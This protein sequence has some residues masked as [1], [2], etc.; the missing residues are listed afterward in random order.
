MKAH[1]VRPVAVFHE[2]IDVLR[3]GGAVLDV[4]RVLVHVERQDG[5]RSGHAVRMIG[6]PLIHE[7]AIAVRMR[8]QHP[9]G[10]P[11]VGIMCPCCWWCLRNVLSSA[12]TFM[13]TPRLL[14]RC[15]LQ[16]RHT[17]GVAARLLTSRLSFENYC[18]ITTDTP[19]GSAGNRRDTRTPVWALARSRTSA[20]EPGHKSPQAART[21]LPAAALRRAAQQRPSDGRGA[22]SR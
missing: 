9:A 18:P 14:H 2:G 16:D 13:G 4:V 17:T 21:Q 22:G 12:A 3:R 15:A 6:R 19:P 1:D 8:E 7:L 10:S 11:T 20:E 5:R